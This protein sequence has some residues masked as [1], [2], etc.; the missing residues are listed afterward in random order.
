MKKRAMADG[1]RLEEEW[2]SYYRKLWR[3]ATV[4]IANKKR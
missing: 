4:V 1:G 3:Y 2:G